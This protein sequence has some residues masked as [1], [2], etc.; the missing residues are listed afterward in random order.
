MHEKD[1]IPINLYFY[2]PFLIIREPDQ[3]NGIKSL[4]LIIFLIGENE[5]VRSPYGRVFSISFR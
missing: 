2:I 5:I 4:L 3:R 1:V